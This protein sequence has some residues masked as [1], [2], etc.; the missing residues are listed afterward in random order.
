MALPVTATRAEP[1]KAFPAMRRDGLD[2]QLLGHFGE[3]EKLAGGTLA[4][5]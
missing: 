3:L 5:V 2:I 1:K 4:T